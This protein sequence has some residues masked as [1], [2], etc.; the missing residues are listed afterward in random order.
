MTSVF[1]L[2]AFLFSRGPW[3]Y[4][5]LDLFS[6]SLGVNYVELLKE[7]D[8]E[9]VGPATPF[10][11]AR[12]ETGQMTRIARRAV[13]WPRGWYITDHHATHEW[14]RHHLSRRAPPVRSV[15][16]KNVLPEF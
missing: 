6:V 3:D 13:L 9:T 15:L 16:G 2:Y 4:S 10:A 14:D 12:V 7:G 5:H 8:P 1:E 11:A